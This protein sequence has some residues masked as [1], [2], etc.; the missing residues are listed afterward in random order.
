LEV[1]IREKCFAESATD[2]INP[3]VGDEVELPAAQLFLLRSVLQSNYRSDYLVDY[4]DKVSIVE[5]HDNK[6]INNIKQLIR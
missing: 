6:F 3:R 4:S 2:G 1:L 5:I